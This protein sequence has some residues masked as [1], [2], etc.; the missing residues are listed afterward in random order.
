MFESFYFDLLRLWLL[1]YP[2]PLRNKQID[3]KSVLEAPDKEA[4]TELVVAKEIN[5]IVY[6]TPAEWFKYLEDK[7]NLGC[8]SKDEIDASPRPKPRATCSSTT[9]LSRT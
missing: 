4:I 6:K 3:F 2:Q 1:A 5:E 8:P 9:E 7:V